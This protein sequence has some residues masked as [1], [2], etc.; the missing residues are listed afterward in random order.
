MAERTGIATA[1]RSPLPIRTWRFD[2]W[3]FDPASG[4]L[5]R[6]GEG[7][8]ERLTPQLARL[9]EVI[10]ERGGRVVRREVLYRA[11]WGDT[12]VDQEHGLNFLVRQLRIALGDDARTPLFVETVRG[13]G[14]RFLRPARLKSAGAGGRDA[15]GFPRPRRPRRLALA[16]LALSTGGLAV[17]ALGGVGAHRSGGALATPSE[18]ARQAYLEGR[19]L[20]TKLTLED[21]RRAAA[22]YQRAISLDPDFAPAWVGLASVHQTLV[23]AGAEPAREGLELARDA[24]AAALERDPDHSQA[25]LVLGTAE[26]YLHLDWDRAA[27]HL[28]RARAGDPESAEARLWHARALAA[29]GHFDAAIAEA[30]SA[31]DVDPESRAALV[32][33]GWFYYFAGRYEEAAAVSRRSLE[34]EPGSLA[35]LQCLQLSSLVRGADREARDATAR[36]AALLPGEGPGG[37]ERPARDS[38]ESIAELADRMAEACDSLTLDRARLLALEGRRAEALAALRDGLERRLWWSPF[39]AVDPAF[40]ELR[41]DEGFRLLL[42]DVREGRV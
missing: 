17:L 8:P 29:G 23:Q 19:Y 28:A 40:A 1:A 35:A 30:R 12:H 33:L 36:I 41:G 38:V 4:D 2:G 24:A 32:D 13:R 14:Y 16:L 9:L 26:L 6:P 18:P 22:R 21:Q 5:W 3:R 11:I 39:V 10:L 34:L 25:H 27:E 15:E 7:E 37:E 31:L 42:A 20:A